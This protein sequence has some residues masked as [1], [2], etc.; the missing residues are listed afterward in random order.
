MR[1][2]FVCMLSWLEKPRL[3]L[4]LL[5]M[6]YLLSGVGNSAWRTSKYPMQ[7][8]VNGYYLYLPAVFIHQDVQLRFVDS[9]TVQFDR[10]YFL[11]PTESGGYLN[12]YPPGVAFF[13]AP[14]FVI[15]H[16]LSTTAGW[17]ASGYAPAYRLSV[18]LSN[19]V[20]AL[21]GLWLLMR[22]LTKHFKPFTVSLVLLSIGAATNFL[23]YTSLVSGLTHVYLFFLFAL[24][25]HQTQ[26]W[27]ELRQPRYFYVIC[28]TLGV[29]AMVRPTEV[30]VGIIPVMLVLGHYKF[31]VWIN[32]WRFVMVYL[33]PG[34][35]LFILAMSPVFI[36]WKLATGDFL[37]YSYEQEGFYFDRPEQLIYGL[38]GFRKGWFVY[39]PIALFF[40]AGIFFMHKSH[41]RKWQIP[42]SIYVLLNVYVVLS[43]WC[44]WYGGCFG[45]RAFIPMFVVLSLPFAIL[46]ERFSNT[47]RRKV[48]VLVG[49]SYFVLLNLFQSLQ[50]KRQLIHHDGM[51]WAAYQF[52]FLRLNLSDEEKAHYK[53]LIQPANYSETGKKL[54][55]YFKSETQEK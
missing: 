52:T 22:V 30:L 35:L 6:V 4:L 38:F 10:K 25:V 5:A 55:E 20:F 51:S 42:V 2:L 54:S 41:Y 43:W 19:I 14:F 33:L 28:F 48:L 11:F 29:V 16:A 23:F 37:H 27:L 18:I 53:T 39:T 9:D 1:A 32:V 46:I 26:Q 21:L 34:M 13:Y 7:Y 40:V 15:A 47:A 50:Y 45:Q 8:D 49:I 17:E 44:W 24:V 36:Y 3:V 12:K 31:D